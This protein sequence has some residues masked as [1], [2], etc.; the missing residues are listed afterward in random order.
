MMKKSIIIYKNVSETAQKLKNLGIGEDFCIRTAFSGEN[1]LEQMRSAGLQLILLDMDM[2]EAEQGSSLDFVAYIRS[3][4]RMPIIMVSRQAA[5]TAMIEALNAGADDYVCAD[6]SPSELFARIRSQLRPYV[7]LLKLCNNMDKI[8]KVD[9]LEIDDT[10]RKVMVDGREVKLTPIEYKILRFLVKE[11]GRVLSSSQ[12][13]ESIWN[14][15]A[16]GADNVIA[17]HIRHIREKIE[18]DPRQP[19]YLKV[20]WGTGYKVG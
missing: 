20:V 9:G 16:I 18:T 1:L 19:C 4:T 17:V 10:Q 2:G 11:K 3:K 14:M 8:Y 15:R 6:C 12:I 13:Y 5:E 7:Q